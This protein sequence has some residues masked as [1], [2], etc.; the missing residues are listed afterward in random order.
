MWHNGSAWCNVVKV[1]KLF[2]VMFTT[3]LSES[4]AGW[5]SRATRAD[6]CVAAETGP[7]RCCEGSSINTNTWS[8]APETT[9]YTTQSVSYVDHRQTELKLAAATLH[10][11][12][13][14]PVKEYVCNQYTFFF[15]VVVLPDNILSLDFKVFSWDAYSEPDILKQEQLRESNSSSLC[16]WKF[17]FQATQWEAEVKTSQK[18]SACADKFLLPSGGDYQESRREGSGGGGA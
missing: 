5:L 6:V 1:N 4:E 3:F 11:Q 9:C 12:S 16:V 10:T 18:S 17:K 8:A 13:E 7:N 14:G 15:V 2:F